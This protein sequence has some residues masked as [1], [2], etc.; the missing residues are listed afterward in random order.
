MTMVMTMKVLGGVL[1]SGS[2]T[3][4][5]AVCHALLDSYL[6]NLFFIQT[7]FCI[8]CSHKSPIK[9]FKPKKI[10]AFNKFFF[11]INRHKSHSH[12]VVKNISINLSLNV[13]Q[14]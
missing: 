2:Y 10:S 12:E 4:L 6:I 1:F 5:L 8:V 14:C 7:L 11:F 13:Q 3:F 9:S